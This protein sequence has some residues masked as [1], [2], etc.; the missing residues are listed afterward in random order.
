MASNLS[1][2]YNKGYF[3]GM[4]WVN[5]FN[6]DA[7]EKEIIK[8]YINKKNQ[9]I[10][11]AKLQTNVTTILEDKFDHL[12]ICKFELKVLNPG[13]LIGTGNGHGVGVD[14]E[15][16]LGFYL[17][18]TTGMPVIPGHSIKGAIRSA[19]PNFKTQASGIGIN[20]HSD[21]IDTCKIRALGIA[22]QLGWIKSEN[23][24]IKEYF[25]SG[26]VDLY[27]KVHILEQNIFEGLIL[28]DSIL[29]PISIYHRDIFLEAIPTAMNNNKLFSNDFIT[30]HIKKGKSYRQS[31]LTE[32]VP[33]Q[34]LKIA[35]GVIYTFQ[36]YLGNYTS[37]ITMEQREK[38]FINILTKK[39]VGAKTNVG[40][41][42]FSSKLNLETLTS[43]QEQKS[44][45]S[46]TRYNG[47]IR[48]GN[49]LCA[50]VIDQSKKIVII[51]FAGERMQLRIFGNCPQNGSIIY[52]SM[53]VE[54]PKDKLRISSITFIRQV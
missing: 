39:G 34:F 30:P 44:Q 7:K 2:F 17:D 27:D 9:T 16:K 49:E 28:Q 5:L 6:N 37:I 42:Q 14:N 47:T 22:S 18:Y 51:D 15:F 32:P 46:L 54:G 24:D 31:M 20:Y 1:Y 36:F 53:N 25:D 11:N 8:D 12:E 45:P 35:P 41:G 43:Y 38:L 40:Y 33:L 50:E 19:F 4:D 52:G 26:A 29:K 21:D 3:N 13:L 10:L 23:K 48:Q